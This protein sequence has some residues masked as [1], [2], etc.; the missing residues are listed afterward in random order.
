VV[1]YSTAAGL[2]LRHTPYDTYISAL[3][4]ARGVRILTQPDPRLIEVEVFGRLS[5]GMGFYA[6]PQSLAVG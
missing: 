1:F 3:L 5:K 6:I 2:W 4:A